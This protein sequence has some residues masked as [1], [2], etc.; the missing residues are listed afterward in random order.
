MKRNQQ[1]N[2]KQA[3]IVKFVFGGI[4]N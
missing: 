1:F 4:D 3:K 2:R